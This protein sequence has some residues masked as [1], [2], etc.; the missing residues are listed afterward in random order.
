MIRAS[1]YQV[2][3]LQLDIVE[4]DMVPNEHEILI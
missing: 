1:T 3:L 4:K 2:I